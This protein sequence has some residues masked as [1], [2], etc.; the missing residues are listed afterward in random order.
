MRCT[1][2]LFFNLFLQ[3]SLDEL[4]TQFF[5]QDNF[6]EALKCFGEDKKIRVNYLGACHPNV[7]MVLNNVA[8][9]NFQ[10]GN[11]VAAV[12]T[13]NEARDIQKSFVGSPAKADLDL[14]HVATTLCNIG[15]MQIRLK[16][17]DVARCIFEEAL[18]IQQSVYGDN[19]NKAIK[20]TL[21]NME[22]T[23]AFHS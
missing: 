16:Q 10:L 20:D 15:Y 18:L 12:V 3:L 6:H 4:G 19:N 8:C 21:S 1:H 14:L 13:L 11:H 5:A 17:Y 22:F 9:C 7:A 23:N 2:F